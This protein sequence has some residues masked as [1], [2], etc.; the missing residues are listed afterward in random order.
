MTTGIGD[1]TLDKYKFK[2]DVATYKERD[3][4]DFAPRATVPGGSV[5][6]SDLGLYQPL[7]QSDWRHG[8]GFQHYT[9]PS[10]YSNTSGNVDTRQDGVA[11]LYTNKVES[12]TD[13]ANK[14]GFTR[15]GSNLWSWG[16]GG[17]RKYNGSTWSA[18]SFSG[19][20]HYLT[21]QSSASAADSL[22]FK[23]TIPTFGQNKILIVSLG[24]R[25][26]VA[27]SSVTFNGDALVQEA[28]VGTA[29]KSEI[30]YLLNP[31]SG[32]HDVVVTLASATS[33]TA[34]ARSY[35]YVDQDDPLGIVASTSGTGTSAS[36]N[37]TG[38]TGETVIDSFAKQGASTDN[39]VMGAVQTSQILQSVGTTTSMQGAGS[40]EPGIASTTMS[41]TWTNS[42]AYAIMGVAIKPATQSFTGDVNFAFSNGN[43]LFYCPDNDRIRRIS[44]AGVDSLAGLDGDS[45]DFN[46]MAIQNGYM[47]AGV[48]GTNQVHYDSTDDLSE[49]EGS[50]D[51]PGTI[52]CGMGNLPLRGAI[53]YGGSL[54]VART[55]GLWVI[56]EDGISRRAIDFSNETS[57][58]NFRSMAVINGFLI[59]PVRDKVLQWNGTRVNDITPLKLS[60]TYPYKTYGRFDN[61][62]SVDNFLYMTARTNDSTYTESLICYDGIGYHKL[63]DLITDGTGEVSAMGY[64]SSLNR[65]WIHVDNDADKTYYIQLQSTS[66]FPYPYFPTT[67]THSLY[68]SYMDMG[69]RRVK[70]SMVS[71][72]VSTTNTSQT[73]YIKVYYK[74]DNETLWVHWD[75]I[76]TPGMIELKY[77]GGERT[78]EFNR[79]QFRFDFVTDATDSSPILEEYTLRFLM[80]PDVSYGYNFWVIAQDY[81]QFG[82]SQDERRAIE[83]RE[84]LLSLRD[85][86]RPI[87]FIDLIGETHYGYITAVTGNPVVR[88]ADDEFAAEVIEYAF[89]INFVETK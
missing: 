76:V 43:Y 78:R 64:D 89:Q 65:L 54:Y 13:N 81:G 2:I 11:M 50:T 16:G 38:Y 37:V 72:F 68:T 34:G 32:E 75:D 44:A 15:F 62:V 87:K 85:S 79:A 67:G 71:M 73:Q 82:E 55:D 59:F 51:D 61:F 56:G 23:H 26:N 58:N 46:W 8:F 66:P 25:T 60:D 69:F 33:L 24:I 47:Y 29:P 18:H 88:S 39:L 36:I 6:M 4:V 83:V 27:V 30:W 28:T 84:Q 41:W 74:L 3:I 7:V 40:Y 17:L 5:V 52:Y 42:R 1:I 86:K 22:T 80:R 35:L 19:I 20:E 70:K 10:G 45:I 77:P 31:D 21:T 49:L 63:T 9:D 12:D 53:V 14:E 48:E 57:E